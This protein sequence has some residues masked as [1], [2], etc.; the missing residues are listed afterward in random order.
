MKV[1]AI[2]LAIIVSG[3]STFAASG[4]VKNITG[5]FIQLDGQLSQFTEEQWK[6]ELSLMKDIGMDTVIIQYSAY[7]ERF[8]YPSKY[9][10]TDEISPDESIA[11]LREDSH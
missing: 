7:G 2:F 6:G 8:Y 1:I 4:E 3:L 10:K 5:A 11:E 9:M